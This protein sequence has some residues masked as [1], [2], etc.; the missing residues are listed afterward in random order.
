MLR[1]LHDETIVNEETANGEELSRNYDEAQAA[2]N[3]AE[4]ERLSI[5]ELAEVYYQTR[6]AQRARQNMSL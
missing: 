3:N 4:G 6:G 1:S 5:D 2:L